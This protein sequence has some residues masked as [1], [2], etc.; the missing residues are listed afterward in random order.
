MYFYRFDDGDFESLSYHLRHTDWSMTEVYLSEQ[1]AGRIFKEVEAERAASLALRAVEGDRVSGSMV[2]EFKEALGSS[3]KMEIETRLVRAMK[4]VDE[5]SLV[6]DF[7]PSG[8]C[9][10]RT[11]GREGRSQ[12][13]LRDGDDVH[14]MLHRATEE[15]CEGCPNLLACDEVKANYSPSGDIHSSLVC[16][17]PMLDAIIVERN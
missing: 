10:G 8:L 16:S 7:V 11:P 17:S 1:E 6:M 2:G 14:V 9:F 13:L 3:I 12:C 4:Y 15:I 5:N